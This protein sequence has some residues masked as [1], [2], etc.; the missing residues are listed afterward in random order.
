MFSCEIIN[1]NNNYDNNDKNIKPRKYLYFI[2]IYNEYLLYKNLNIKWNFFL[3]YF[4]YIFSFL[5]KFISNF[6]INLFF[7]N[8]NIKYETNTIMINRINTIIGNLIL[9]ILISYIIFIK[10]RVQY[11]INMKFNNIVNNI[12]NNYNSNYNND[13][14]YVNFK[15]NSIT[16]FTAFIFPSITLFIT[17]LMVQKKIEEI[18]YEKE[19]NFHKFVK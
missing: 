3:N 11:E 4:I 9:I 10:I 12:I 18:K 2:P 5:I 1:Y 13:Y 19:I 8:Q 7:Y 14:N 15:I 6:I 17:S 16:L